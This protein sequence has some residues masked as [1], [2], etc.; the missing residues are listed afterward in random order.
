MFQLHRADILRLHVIALRA[1]R[2]LQFSNA[3]PPK[4]KQIK[5]LGLTF[6]MENLTENQLDGYLQSIL[7]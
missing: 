1:K 2:V 3:H 4:I 5:K 7:N 6:H